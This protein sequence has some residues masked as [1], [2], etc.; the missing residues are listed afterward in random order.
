M[1]DCPPVPDGNIG[2][3]GKVDMSPN[4]CE[5]ATKRCERWAVTPLLPFTFYLLGGNVTK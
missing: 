5:G 3:L 2:T 1:P 4:V